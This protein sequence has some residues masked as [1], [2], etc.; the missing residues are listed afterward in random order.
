MM[1]PR[2]VTLC[3]FVLGCAS[4]GCDDRRESATAP[5]GA[6]TA[7]RTFNVTFSQCNNAEP[8]RAAQNQLM[9]KLWAQHPDVRFTILDAQQDDKRQIDQVTTVI[10]QKPDLLIVAPNQRAPLTKV[11]GDAMAAG[12]PVI[13][14][15]RDVAEPNYT[16]YIRCDNYEIGRLAGELAVA[17]LTKKYGSPKGNIVQ[18]QGLLGVE[19]EANRDKGANDVWKQHPEIRVVH[20]AVA[21]WVQSK[22]RD[23]M[24]EALNANPLID[25]VFGH[26]DP[27]A[28]GAYLAA[29]DKRREKEIIFIGADGLGGEAGGIKK[30]A[31]GILAGTFVY[32]LCADKAVEVGNRILREPEFVPEKTYT[33]PSRAVTPANAQA[34]Y[35]E[36]TF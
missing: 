10:R 23:R 19:G 28:I 18:I 5:G 4:V 31:D 25:V 26:N 13:C 33:M 34:L 27:M 8:Y 32:P 29:K 24:T 17:E 9:T 6:A 11:M 35:D 1:F 2:L 3:L 15:E 12:I 36:L 7:G 21:D 20:R 14:L 16:T 22:A 30:V